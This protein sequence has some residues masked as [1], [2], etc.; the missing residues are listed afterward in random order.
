LLTFGFVDPVPLVPEYEKKIMMDMAMASIG[1]YFE[2]FYSD[3]QSHRF[4]LIISEPLW[5]RWQGNA[6]EFGNENDA[7]VYWV[8]APVLC[9]YEPIETFLR[10]GTQLLIPRT[11]PLD[12]PDVI[13]PHERED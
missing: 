3:L 12:D 11:T 9:Y 10:F 5:I 2:P 7:W 13:C 4:S 8:S 6:N 1:S